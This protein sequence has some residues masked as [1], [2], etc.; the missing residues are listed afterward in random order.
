[1][2][3]VSFD[4]PEGKGVGLGYVMLCLSFINVIYIYALLKFD[5]FEALFTPSSILL[6]VFSVLAVAIGVF[7][8]VTELWEFY[9][10]F[11]WCLALIFLNVALF[12]SWRNVE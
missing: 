6:L 8:A 7:V 4:A 12:V 11:V 5:R 3:V 10:Y 1:M 2:I 9:L